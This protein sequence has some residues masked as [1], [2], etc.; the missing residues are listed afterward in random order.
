[1][2]FACKSDYT[3]VGVECAANAVIKNIQRWDE[4]VNVNETLKC[5]NCS[6]P[7]K[8]NALDSNKAN[9]PK[10]EQPKVFL[11]LFKWPQ[12]KPIKQ[13]MLHV[14]REYLHGK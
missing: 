5:I 6:E 9:P 1:M 14:Q 8:P 3:Q 2:C 13:Q 12:K 7:T 4:N 11:F 10:V